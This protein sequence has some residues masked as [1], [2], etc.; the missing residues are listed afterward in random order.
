[1]DRIELMS[2]LRFIPRWLRFRWPLSRYFYQAE[3]IEDARRWA[4]EYR[5]DMGWDLDDD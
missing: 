4:A 2:I 3:D 1:M 5:R